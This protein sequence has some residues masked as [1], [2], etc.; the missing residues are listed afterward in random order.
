M[1]RDS[2]RKARIGLLDLALDRALGRQEQ[3][4]GELLGERRAALHHLVGV[5]VLDQRA[6][7]AEEVDAEVLEEA[8]ILGGERRLDEMIGQI[9]SSGD[10]VVVQDAAL[11]DLVAVLVQEFD[12]RTCRSLMLVLVELRQRRDGECSRATNRPPAPS[13]SAFR[14]QPR[15]MSSL[16]AGQPEA[17]EEAS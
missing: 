3:V 6:G 1:K 12:A 14:D 9:S 5:G 15:C 2:S 17:G 11:A 8:P 4:L 10:G 13:V 16:P 7:G